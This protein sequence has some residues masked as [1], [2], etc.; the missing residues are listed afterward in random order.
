MVGSRVQQTCIASVEKA[1]EVV[2]NGK[3][4]TGLEAWQPRAEGA[5]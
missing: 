2:R 4:G 1:A 3:G 5:Q